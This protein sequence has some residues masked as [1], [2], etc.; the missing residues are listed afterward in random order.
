MGQQM[1]KMAHTGHSFMQAVVARALDD[2]TKAMSVDLEV[3][4]A[5]DGMED[6]NGLKVQAH[7][8]PA[9]EKGAKPFVRATFKA[10]DGKGEQLSAQFQKVLDETKAYWDK[11]GADVEE[12]FNN[13]DVSTDD[14]DS[15]LVLITFH[16]DVELPP[17]SEDD[18]EAEKPTME[19]SIKTGR[20]FQEMVDN[21][22]GCELTLPGGFTMTASTELAKAIMGTLKEAG[23]AG[24]M[25]PL[26]AFSK[27]SS[28]TEMRYDTAELEAA[29]CDEEA[30][31]GRLQ[32]VEEFKKN[33]KSML[34]EQIGAEA[35]EAARG[36]ADFADHLESFEVG[37]GLPDD[38]EIHLDFE[39]FEL[40]PV[41]AKFLQ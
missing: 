25:S 33:A 27:L 36:L 11:S 41:I 19:I 21:I 28:H 35:V 13:F 38:Y 29:T 40:T 14:D 32:Q 24:P 31:E 7:L 15:D 23:M 18:D 4:F 6:W 26:A 22:H 10:Q 2:N 1:H 12:M 3:T 39:G 17:F 5:P 16:P 37:G 20:D 8:R 34:S 9:E 30:V